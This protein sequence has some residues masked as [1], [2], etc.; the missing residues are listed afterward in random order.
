MTRSGNTGD[1]GKN[2]AANRPDYRQ[3]ARLAPK[4]DVGWIAIS[5]CSEKLG[6][7]RESLDHARQVTAVAPSSAAARYQ[8]SREEGLS[9]NKQAA[10]KAL[11]RANEL[12][13]KAP[14]ATKQ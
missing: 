1:V 6:R 2:S 8:L 9:A 5:A 13:S 7:K 11:A 3:V 10:D 14:K 4:A 12:R